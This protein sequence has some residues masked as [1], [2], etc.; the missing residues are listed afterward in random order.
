MANICLYKIR[1]KGT[2][3]ACYALVNMMPLYSWEKEYVDE[4]G[5]DDEYSLLFTGACKWGVDC[6]TSWD[7]E[8]TTPYTAE[9]IAKIQDGDDWGIPLQQKSMLLNCEIFCNSKDIDDPSWSVYEHYDKGVVINDECPKELHIKR[10]RDYDW[11]YEAPTAGNCI[12]SVP[13]IDAPTCKVRF[14]DN[15]SYW[16]FGDVKVGDVVFVEG[17][18]AGCKGIVKEVS[19]QE[20]N[21]GFYHV[22]STVANVPLFVEDDILAIWDSMKAKDRKPYLVKIGLEEKTVKKK[23]CSMAENKWIEM[24][25]A[26]AVWPSFVAELANG[27]IQL[28]VV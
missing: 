12:G 8:L 19:T 14:M 17:A 2:K 4:E 10:G 18:K 20:N 24:A 6:Y 1:V 15:R 11:G 28:D 5:T 27:N 16:Y 3:A 13:A 25:I 7:K 26:G 22:T 23:F 21:A 9:R